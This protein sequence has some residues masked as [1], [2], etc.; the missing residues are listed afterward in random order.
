[1]PKRSGFRESSP[2]KYRQPEGRIR[3]RRAARGIAARSRAPK[4]ATPKRFQRRMSAASGCS[5]YAVHPAVGSF[6]PARLS[7][8]G[9]DRSAAESASPA[10]TP[11]PHFVRG[12][13]VGWVLRG[14][15]WRNKSRVDVQHIVLS[16][17]YIVQAAMD[18]I[19]L[20]AEAPLLHAA[21]ANVRGHHRPSRP[22]MLLPR[23][24]RRR[25]RREGRAQPGKDNQRNP[26]QKH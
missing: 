5:P 2:A 7:R 26:A 11:Q 4:S 24:G 6:P 17:D 23:L 13:L 3:T 16:P 8:A 19:S 22:N 1:M 15:G 14:I 21:Q 20:P 12:D 25:H 9:L 10:D 18:V